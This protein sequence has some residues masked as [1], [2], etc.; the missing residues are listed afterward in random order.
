MPC[1]SDSV[2]CCCYSDCTEYR[3]KDHGRTWLPVEEA[4]GAS[5]WPE[6]RAGLEVSAEKQ[7]S[8]LVLLRESSVLL[9]GI[10]GTWCDCFKPYFPVTCQGT[11]V[12]HPKSLALVFGSVNAC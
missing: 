5:G 9:L 10:S 4:A 3:F 6:P 2:C 8:T 7:H 1:F 12:F 11:M